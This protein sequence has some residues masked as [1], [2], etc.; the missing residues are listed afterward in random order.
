MELSG[1][2]QGPHWKSF[3]AYSGSYTPL[4]GSHILGVGVVIR[5]SGLGSSLV[6]SCSCDDLTGASM[7]GSWSVCSSGFAV[8]EKVVSRF[9]V[10]RFGR[11]SLS[12]A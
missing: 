11:S 2:S 6:S 10:H 3:G 12:V 8:C 7:L 9:H 4:S 1:S 5:G